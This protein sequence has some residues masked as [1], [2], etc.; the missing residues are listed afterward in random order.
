MSADTCQAHMVTLNNWQHRTRTDTVNDRNQE[1]L[2]RQREVRLLY[3][4]VQWTLKHCYTCQVEL[5][6]PKYNVTYRCL[7]VTRD[8]LGIVAW[9]R[10]Y[11]FCNAPFETVVRRLRMFQSKLNRR[12]HPRPQVVVADDYVSTSSSLP[13]ALPFQKLLF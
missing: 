11:Y 3:S 10:V 1:P 7:A 6:G 2:E 5:I 12:N 8:A 9:T 13:V 4:T